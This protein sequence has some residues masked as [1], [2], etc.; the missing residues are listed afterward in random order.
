M[1]RGENIRIWIGASNLFFSFILLMLY[2]YG[3]GDNTMLATGI[4][5]GFVALWCKP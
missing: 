2:A 4:F 1:P 5:T 3:D